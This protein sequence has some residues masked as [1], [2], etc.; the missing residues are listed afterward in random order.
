MNPFTR[1]LRSQERRAEPAGFATFV[2]AWDALEALVI[3]V[4]RAG[5][6]DA[7]TEAAYRQLKSF[8]VSAYPHWAATLAPYWRDAL[9]AGQPVPA[10]PFARLLATPSA[11]VFV[12]NFAAMQTLPPAREAINRYLLTL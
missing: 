3:H 1:F 10:D 9:E 2:E 5:S 8:L 7:A 11:T 6:A 12:G 4:Y